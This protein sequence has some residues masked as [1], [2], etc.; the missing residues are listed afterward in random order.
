MYLHKSD[1]L[2]ELKEHYIFTLISYFSDTSIVS[3]LIYNN[4]T[5][6][7]EKV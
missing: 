3:Y 7:A 6:R 2:D 4:A 5:D 1:K